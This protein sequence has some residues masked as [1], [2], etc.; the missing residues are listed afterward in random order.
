MLR[1]HRQS[2]RISHLA[3]ILLVALL[4]CF[5][6]SIT[7]KRDSGAPLELRKTGKQL[8]DASC[9]FDKIKSVNAEL[10][11]MLSEL[12]TT[13]FFRYWKVNLHRDC[14]FWPENPLCILKDCSVI[15]AD[16]SELPE[17]LKTST[18]SSVDSSLFGESMFSLMTDSCKFEEADFCLVEGDQSTDGCYINLLKNPERFTG[19][20]GESPQRVWGAIYNE[21]CFNVNENRLENSLSNSQKEVSDQCMEKRVFY[22]LISGLHTSIST[23]ICDQWLDRQ[24]GVWMRNLTC[25]E[26]RVGNHKERIENLLFVQTLVVRAVAKLSP[27]LRDHQVHHLC[28]G[29]GADTA[30]IEDLVERIA[31]TSTSCGPTFDEKALFAD[32]GAPLLLE[33]FKTHFRNISRIMDCVGCE[34]CRLWGKLQV[35]GLGTALKILFSY[36]DKPEGYRLTRGEVVALFNTMHR[37]AESV[38]ALDRFRA[39][40]QKVNEETTLSDRAAGRT[41]EEIEAKQPPR[42]VHPALKDKS[43]SPAAD[44]L[45]PL[46]FI[47]ML[48]YTQFTSPRHYL[49][50]LAGFVL[51]VLGTARIA[52]KAWQIQSGK[53]QLPDGY[54]R[55]EDGTVV[56]DGEVEEEFVE[57][58]G[59]SEEEEDE[60][61]RENEGESD[62]SMLA[63]VNKAIVANGV[64][65]AGKQHARRRRS[66]VA[67]ST[68]V[69]ETVDDTTVVLTSSTIT[70]SAVPVTSADPTGTPPPNGIRKTPLRKRRQG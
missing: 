13:S 11:P 49:P 62:G 63:S 6:V 59:G 54:I 45:P 29:S 55:T 12:V 18:L 24:T 36:D 1:K 68:K 31:D 58:E 8:H 34:K 37:L 22:R 7:A 33:E 23:H 41:P 50:F 60:W 15:E 46:P 48:T 19:Y 52:H 39:L 32:P 35:T 43:P 2:P 42:I 14:P 67:K 57:V 56:K 4:L 38:D 17:H 25:Y 44:Q 27:F 30:R 40:R 64:R 9:A 51:V 3:L 26:E 28:T 53:F 5:P 20:H 61:Y 16:E 66:S 47:D 69:I 70:T 10:Y 21:N 65:V